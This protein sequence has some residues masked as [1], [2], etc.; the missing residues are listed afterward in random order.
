MTSSEILNAIMGFSHPH[1]TKR[2]DVLDLLETRLIMVLESNQIQIED[3]SYLLYEL[4]RFQ[5]GSK[6]L[7]NSLI[8]K[9]DQE[10]RAKRTQK[11]TTKITK[12]ETDR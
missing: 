8:K 11:Q 7:I 3:A 2:L 9:I 5:I 6:I 4:S 1:C 12:A 10:L